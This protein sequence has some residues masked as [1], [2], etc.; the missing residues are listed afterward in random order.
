[1]R[2]RN[3]RVRPPRPERLLVA[4]PEVPPVPAVTATDLSSEVMTVTPAL[5]QRWLEKNHPSNRPVAW[6]RVEAFA[7][8]MRMGAWKLTHQG[9]CFD[10][11]G[12][13]IDGQHRL[14]A[15][16]NADVAVPMLVV[17]N[18]LGTYHDP[19]DRVGP[20]SVATIMGMTTR[21]VSSLNTLRM[22]EAGCKVFSPM[23]LAEADAVI[24]R[25]QEAWEEIRKI[26]NRNKLTGPVVAAIMWALPCG[27]ERA[28]EF[29]H[30]TATGEMIGRG[31][32]IFAFRSWRERNNRLDQW[33]T[34]LATL[35]CLR[36]YLTESPLASVYTSVAGYRAFCSKRRALK[37]ANTPPVDIV[38]TANWTPSRADRNAAEE[39]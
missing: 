39:E 23:T 36:H 33:E 2:G 38:P 16:V 26:P 32:P 21:D 25:H 7:N 17:R 11:E 24:V 28:L 4:V 22:L 5:A 1:M 15:V 30:R 18:R 35:N 13:L 29:M 14:Q 34:A 9:I 8:D 37:I 12:Y 19:I 10:A 27:R 6:R 3:R 31:N 20:R